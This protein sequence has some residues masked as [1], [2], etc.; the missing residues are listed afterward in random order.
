MLFL[1]TIISLPLLLVLLKVVPFLTIL[2]KTVAYT[3]TH[4]GPEVVPVLCFLAFDL[5]LG[6]SSLLILCIDLGTE[7]APAI[8][9]AY[10]K[11]EADVML[12]KPRNVKTDRL[13]SKSLLAYSYLIMGT[14]ES[15]TGFLAYF[16]VFAKYEIPASMLWGA[17][18]NF[19]F[20]NCSP[21]KVR[22][23]LVYSSKQ[24]LDI[25]SE[26]QST[27]FLT[28]VLSQVFHIWMCKTRRVSIFKH[29]FANMMMLFGVIIEILVLVAIIYV[30]FMQFV[31]QS[32]PVD[33]IFI[34]PSLIIFVFCWTYN[35]SRK[36]WVRKYPT[37]S[38]AKYLH[39]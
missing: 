16:L 1:W 37:G 15:L 24:Q 33:A 30:S 34:L 27:F 17:G 31:L 11:Q 35:E 8:S 22:D 39:W 7:I 13:V 6:L 21:L 9:L 3:L 19:F 23:G 26:V 14:A 20:I 12:Q 10:E 4:L 18:K 25:L 29:G 28:I 38:I 2:K 36:S 5:P 32:K